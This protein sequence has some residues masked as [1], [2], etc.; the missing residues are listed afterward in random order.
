MKLLLTLLALCLTLPLAPP[1]TGT[2]EGTVTDAVTG[3]ALAGALV[4]VEALH[5]LAATDREGRYVLTGLPATTH[6]LT[7]ERKGHATRTYSVAINAGTTVTL[8]VALDAESSF[9]ERLREQFTRPDEGVMQ[10]APA[11]AVAPSYRGFRTGSAAPVGGGYPAAHNT[12]D[13]AHFTDNTFQAATEHPLST[14][15]ID[16]DGAAYANMRRFLRHGQR[17]PADAVR[18]EEMVNYFVYD[19]APPTGDAP[20]AVHVD[21]GAAPWNPSH[22]LV[23]VGLQGQALPETERAPSNLVFLLDV[24]GSMNS[25]DKLP[26]L[27]QAFRLLTAELREEDRVAIVVY[28]GASGLVLPSTP[29]SEKAAILDAIDRLEAGGSTAGAAGIELAY[30]VAAEHAAPGVNSRV[31]LAT[32]GDFNV[33]VSSDGALVRLIEEKR[34]QGTFLTV[35]GFGTGN[36]KDN[37]MEQLANHGNGAYYYLDGPLE[38]KKVLVTEL[39]GT[40]YTI[41]KDVKIQVEFNPAQVAAYRLIGYENRLLAAEDFADDTKDAGELGAG[42]TVTALYEVVPVGAETTTDVRPTPSLRY[43]QPRN[44]AG[45]GTEWLTVALRYKTPDGDTSFLLEQPFTGTGTA[46]AARDLQFAASVAAFGMI[47]RESEHKGTATPTLVLDLARPAQGPDVEGY[48]AEF[49]ELVEA[50]RAVTEGTGTASR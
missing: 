7:V 49:I 33:G 16:V 45:S 10:E 41:A 31:I 44:S 25:P 17:P 27:K 14:F 24:S 30:R 26:L 2:L 20:F 13:Y 32:D 23:R 28:A 43:Q 21:E 50:Y 3:E 15:G 1:T 35:L 38:A 34:E 4:Q 36:L 48:R 29:G 6:A 19:Y 9:L 18:I 47:L 39:G 11:D 5:V 37:K 40:L 12:E 22:R 8:D 46:T 42:H